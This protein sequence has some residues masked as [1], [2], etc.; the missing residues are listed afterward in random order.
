MSSYENISLRQRSFILSQA[1]FNILLAVF[2]TS[3]VWLMAFNGNWNRLH[4]WHVFLSTFGISALMAIAISTLNPGNVFVL[5]FSRKSRGLM[6]GILMLVAGLM[7][8]AGVSIKIQDKTDN[9]RAHFNSTHGILGLVTYLLTFLTVIGGLF[10]A[11]AKALPK[12]QL[13]KSCHIFLGIATYCLGIAT[14][15][16]GLRNYF[17]SFQSSHATNTGFIVILVAY[18]AINLVGPALNLF[19]I[20]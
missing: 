7:L 1:I 17:G 4:I 9:N 2:V 16:F 15:C 11:F 5:G 14:L 19:R 3:T 18:S 8:I 12:L 6:H 20:K 13:V 10:V